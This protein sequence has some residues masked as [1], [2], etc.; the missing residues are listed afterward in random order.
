MGLKEEES[1][2]GAPRYKKVEKGGGRNKIRSILGQ[3]HISM[4]TYLVVAVF[5][6]G[7][8]NDIS[9]PKNGQVY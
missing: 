7:V 2:R 1:Y 3:K 9:L 8:L 4:H 5:P 6:K